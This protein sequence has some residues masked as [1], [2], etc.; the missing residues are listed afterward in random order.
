MIPKN[1]SKVVLRRLALCS[2]LSIAGVVNGHGQA[3]S[4]GMVHTAE[5]DLAYE[6]LGSGNALPPIVAVNGGPGLTHAYMVQN[7]VWKRMAAGRRVV[8]YDQRGNG[9]STRLQANAPQTMEAQVADLEAVRVALH[10]DKIDLVGD[11][12]GG[13]VVLAYT[14]AHPDHVRRLVVSDGLPGWKAIVHP[15]QDIFPDLEAQTAEELKAMPK[16]TKADEFGFRAHIRKCF[17]SP[18]LA[19]KYLDRYTNLGFNSAVSEQVGAATQ[20]LDLSAQ[21]P[22]IPVPTLILT[23]RFDVNVAPLTAWRMTKTIP[24]AQLHIFEHS[25]HLPSYEE[26][27]AY[28]QQLSSF[29]SQK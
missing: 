18:E 29:L 21:L 10:A 16:G 15:M 26:P 9:K 22:K 27:E 13:F 14:L 2:L 12:F 11:S 23:G 3:T 25:G 7:D 20:D 17:Y 8:F 4:T 24:G 6:V 28:L 1:A 19:E 5:V